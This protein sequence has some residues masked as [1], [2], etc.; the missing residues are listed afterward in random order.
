MQTFDQSLFQLY[1]NGLITL[2]E[3]LRRASN[4]DEFKL[5]IQGIQSTSDM[6]AEE[7]ER[8]MQSF[9]LEQRPSLPRA[10]Q[11][12]QPPTAYRRAAPAARA[13]RPHGGGAAPGARPSAGYDA[14]E[15]EAAIERLRRRERTS[16]TAATPSASRAAAGAPGHRPRADPAGRCASAGRRCAETEAGSRPRSPRST[17]RRSLD[18]LARRYWKQH[19]RVEPERRL[20][21]LWAFLM[22]RGFAP[23]LVRERLA[24]LWP[25]WSDAL[26]GLEPLDLARGRARWRD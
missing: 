1:K 22:R 13:P 7:M 11:A 20:P 8:T 17:S 19:A 2:D 24:A 26:E 12:A 15:I 21:R 6:A 16:T 18:A 3:A 14:E 9:D 23:A 25:R 4:P 10:R 5:K